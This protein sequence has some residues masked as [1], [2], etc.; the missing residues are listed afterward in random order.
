MPSVESSA[1][2]RTRLPPRCC[3]TSLTSRVFFPPISRIDHE[4]VADL[5]E[6]PLVELRVEDRSDDLDHGPLAAC[7]HVLPP[8]LPLM[9]SIISF[10]IC[11]WRTLL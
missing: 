9:I 3:C 10:V 2:A 8:S 6:M 7:A 4:G 5:G 1:T 11:A